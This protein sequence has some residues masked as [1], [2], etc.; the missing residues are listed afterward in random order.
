MAATIQEAELYHWLI[1]LASFIL[2]TFIVLMHCGKL[3]LLI[4]R[5]GRSLGKLTI[6]NSF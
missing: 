1:N 6:A 3:Q 2:L 4:H 5:A